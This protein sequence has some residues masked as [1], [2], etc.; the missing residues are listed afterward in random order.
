MPLLDL[1]IRLE[2][3]DDGVGDDDGEDETDEDRGFD[4]S[5]GRFGFAGAL[6]TRILRS[7]SADSD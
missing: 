4:E 2:A 3:E 5:P 6:T 7:V 1:V